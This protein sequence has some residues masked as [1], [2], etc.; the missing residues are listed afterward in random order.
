MSKK[1]VVDAAGVPTATDAELLD[2][3]TTVLSTDTALTGVYGLVQKAGLVVA[4]M[5][6]QN[7]RKIDTFNPIV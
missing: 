2:I 1:I 4:G 5:S 7:K 6:F 3:F